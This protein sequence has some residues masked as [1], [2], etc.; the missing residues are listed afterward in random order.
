MEAASRSKLREINWADV[1]LKHTA[2]KA[3]LVRAPCSSSPKCYS[4]AQQNPCGGWR[5][6]KSNTLSRRTLAS[7]R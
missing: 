5:H 2:Q 6:V 1:A 4:Q 3:G 7:S